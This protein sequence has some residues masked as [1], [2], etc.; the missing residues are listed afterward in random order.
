MWGVGGCVYVCATQS[1]LC[2]CNEYLERSQHVS[3]INKRKLYISST[4][5]QNQ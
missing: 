5:K 2:K 1:D 3:Q 4:C